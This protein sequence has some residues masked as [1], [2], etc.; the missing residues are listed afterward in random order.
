MADPLDARPRDRYLARVAAGLRLSD[1]AGRDVVEELAAHIADATTDLVVEGLT[2]DQAEREALAR[3]GS[4]DALAEDIRRAHQTA[5]RLF[6]AAG[7]GLLAAGGGAFRG[8]FIGLFAITG[9]FYLVTAGA[10]VLSRLLHA[11]ITLG[12]GDRG[13]NSAITALA[14]AVALW[15]AVQTGLVALA[16]KSHRPVASL[17]PFVAGI[18]LL[19]GLFAVLNWRTEQNWASAAAILGLPVVAI[20]AAR[21]VREESQ[22]ASRRMTWRSFGV[23]TVVLLAPLLLLF[24]VNIVVEAPSSAGV[25][26][27]ATFEAMWHDTGWDKVGLAVTGDEPLLVDEQIE[28]DGGTVSVDFARPATLVGWHGLRLEV[29]SSR[30]PSAA[31]GPAPD[32]LLSAVPIADGAASLVASARIDGLPGVTAVHGVLTGVAP[33]GGKYVLTSHYAPTSFRGTVVDWLAAVSR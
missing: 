18:G 10:G 25:P 29:W 31:I 33:G 21:R 4:P 11:E 13:W 15:G 5:R 2:A 9:A 16:W 32:R 23:A 24:G 20:V 1:D 3:L 12:M 22:S 27:W 7:G 30:N 6:A 14:V 8:W 28:T 26:Q 19:V 17:R